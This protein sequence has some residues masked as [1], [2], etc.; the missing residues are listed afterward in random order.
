MAFLAQHMTLRKPWPHPRKEREGGDVQT[1][2]GDVDCGDAGFAGV[3][4]MAGV[5][6]VEGVVEIRDPSVIQRVLMGGGGEI[7]IYQD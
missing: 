2:K 7:D 1:F 3:A 4:G 5:A 6:G